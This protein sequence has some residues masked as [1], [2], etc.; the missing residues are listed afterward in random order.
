MMKLLILTYGTEGDTRPLAALG[1]ALMDAGHEAH[2]LADG[3]TLGSAI[4]LGVPSTPIAGDIREA[5]QHGGRASALFENNGFNNSAAELARMS[6]ENAEEWLRTAVRVGKG[7]DAVIISGL[8]GFIGLSA[9]ECLGI[10]GIGAGMFP[11][12]PTAAFP[13]PLLPPG[14]I[15]RV[16]NKLSHRFIGELVW[17]SFRKATN[18]ARA[19][20]CNLP[21]LKSL[22]VGHPI[23]YGVSP[24]LLP[25][26][27]DWPDNAMNCGQWLAPAK[28]WSPPEALIKFLAAG[29]APVYIG[30][31]SM[32]GFNREHFIEA[33]V[34]GLGGRRALF[35]PGWSGVSAPDLPANILVVGD[36][37]HDWLL[38]RTSM[39]VHHGGSGTTH[40]AARAG[41]PS[42]V[43]PF[44]GDQ[45]FWG[46]RLKQAGVGTRL[47]GWKALNA[48]SLAESIRY[49]ERDEVRSRARHLGERMRKEDGLTT[50]VRAIEKLAART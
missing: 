2:L 30:F 14:K 28:Q 1:R 23:L 22:P 27:A 42:I 8:A 16:F 44:A 45:A 21:P 36:T 49:V 9:A 19:R 37:P 50:A 12:T 24:A 18:A 11:L 46:D 29:E 41:V 31:G 26:P 10:K 4:A 15:P 32:G 33:V 20:V 7:C 3:S 38:P 5:L 34:G 43:V 40:S 13:S 39:V 17:R 25:T 35:Y 48:R 47:S 6:N